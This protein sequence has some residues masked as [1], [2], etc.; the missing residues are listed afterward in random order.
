LLRSDVAV[1]RRSNIA[2]LASFIG[3][4]SINSVIWVGPKMSLVYAQS[5]VQP[6]WNV[7]N[8]KTEEDATQEPLAARAVCW[9]AICSICSFIFCCISLGVGSA[10][11][12]ATIH[13]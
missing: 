3:P 6:D 2:H 13:V 12:V 4:V 10:M 8:K 11:W 1:F 7:W 5:P 9:L